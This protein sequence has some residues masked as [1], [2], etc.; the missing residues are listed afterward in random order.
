MRTAIA[1][2]GGVAIAL[3]TCAF[4]LV[5]VVASTTGASVGSQG[6]ALTVDQVT[7]GG[8]LRP[9]AP[10]PEQYLHLV[11]A[12]G[13]VC[14]QIGPAHIAAQIEV[15]SGWNPN[16]YADSGEVPAHGIA[17]FT[18]PTWHTWGADYDVQVSN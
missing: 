16:A 3:I 17:Q 13:Q 5:L 12:A 6:A 10:V 15:E 11:L 18:M 7:T 9:D 1:S 2:L 8:Q 4:G 14:P